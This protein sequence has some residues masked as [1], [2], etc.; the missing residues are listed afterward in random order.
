[1]KNNMGEVKHYWNN[2][3]N[4]KLQIEK[5]HKGKVWET[6]KT[7]DGGKSSLS[8]VQVLGK[9]K[10]DHPDKAFSKDKDKKAESSIT[11]DGLL[12]R[13]NS[14]PDQQKGRYFCTEGS[15]SP[16]QCYKWRWMKEIWK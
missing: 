5:C 12:D 6:I 4:T 2:H 1:M 16:L 3:T 7:Y 11:G 15:R 13:E 14:M 9:V 8:R 10:R